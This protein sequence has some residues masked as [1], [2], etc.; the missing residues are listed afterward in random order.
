MKELT[1]IPWRMP[2][3]AAET[4]VTPV[5]QCRMATRR[6]SA[7]MLIFLSYNLDG[8]KSILTGL[9]REL[10]DLADNPGKLIAHER[11]LALLEDFNQSTVIP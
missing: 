7:S 2:R 3:Y 6:V 1:V 11:S 5:A 8:G 9:F 10:F 4:I